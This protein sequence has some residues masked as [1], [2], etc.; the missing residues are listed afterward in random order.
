MRISKDV[1]KQ[2]RRGGELRFVTYE[3][4]FNDAGGEEVLRALYTLVQTS[5][6]PRE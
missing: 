5:K 6:D 4:R 1:T 2:G 3:S